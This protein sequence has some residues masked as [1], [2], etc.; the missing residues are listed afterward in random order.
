[1]HP[2]WS[3]STAIPPTTD[4]Q[5]NVFERIMNSPLPLAR[6]TKHAATR[7]ARRARISP[8]KRKQR[9]HACVPD[10]GIAIIAIV[11]RPARAA[12]CRHVSSA[13]ARLHLGP[14]TTTDQHRVVIARRVLLRSA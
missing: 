6:S 3:A 7:I 10:A 5:T 12:L 2:A 13:V 1:M 8:P 11:T 14:V 4:L 9:G